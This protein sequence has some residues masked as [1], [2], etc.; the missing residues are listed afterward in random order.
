MYIHP[1]FLF[2]VQFS[3]IFDLYQRDLVDQRKSA[4]ARDNPQTNAPNILDKYLPDTDEANGQILD[5]KHTQSPAVRVRL[6][7]SN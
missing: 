4:R 6:K 2:L 5:D 7:F 1:L 3:I